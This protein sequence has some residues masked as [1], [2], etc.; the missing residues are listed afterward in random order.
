MDWDWVPIGIMLALVGGFYLW[1][2][3]L[4]FSRGLEIGKQTVKPAQLT[5]AKVQPAQAIGNPSSQPCLV[6]GLVRHHP[7]CPENKPKPRA[8]R[9]KGFSSIRRAL[10]NQP[11]KENTNAS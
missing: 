3:H 1:S 7:D 11:E 10:E 6:C 4:A 2:L 8:E 5:R 9:W